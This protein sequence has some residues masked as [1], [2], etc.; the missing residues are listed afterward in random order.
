[1]RSNLILFWDPTDKCYYSTDGR[2]VLGNIECWVTILIEL[3]SFCFGCTD[4]MAE[5][6][7]PKYSPTSKKKMFS[8]RFFAFTL[9]LFSM[10]FFSNLSEGSTL[11]L[12]LITVGLDLVSFLKST[13]GFEI[14][15]FSF[16][17]QLT[18]RC[19]KN[20][21][22]SDPTFSNLFVANLL[23][24]KDM[25]VTYNN[26]REKN[27]NSNHIISRILPKRI[28]QLSYNIKDITSEGSSPST[29]KSS[30]RWVSRCSTQHTPD[31]ALTAI[32][33]AQ[34]TKNFFSE[35]K[36]LVGCN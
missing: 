30:Q 7:G 19:F 4:T 36:A 32:E 13:F 15:L 35:K 11:P 20:V 16:C 9:L 6:L 1:M 22:T 29:A 2:T 24:E 31:Y 21:T 10:W 25:N 26:P 28:L 33:L 14:A 17:S 5:S 34:P 18:N 3:P 23:Q 12:T 8:W 27:K